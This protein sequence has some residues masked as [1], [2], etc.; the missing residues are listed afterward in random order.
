MHKTTTTKTKR[1]FAKVLVTAV[2]GIVGEGIIKSLKFANIS[3]HTPV[4]YEIF[5]VDISAQAAGLY[6][7]DHGIL[8]PPASSPNYIDFIIKIIKE[9]QIDALYVGS[10]VELVNI[11]KAKKRIETETDA[12][13]ITNPIEVIDTARDKWKTFEFLKSSHLPLAMSSLPQDKEKLIQ[14]YNFPLVVKP[15][16][17]YGSLHFY[18]VNNMEETEQAINMIQ[19]SGWRAMVQ[20]YL[21]ANYE[22]FTSGI[23]IDRTGRYVMSSITIRKTPKSGQ[24]YK[25]VIDSFDEIRKSA[26][27]VAKKLG[28]RSA[29]NIQ[30]KFNGNEAKVFEINPR[31]SATTPMRA[32][33]GINEPDIIFRNTILGEDIRITEYEKMLCLRYWNE[34]YVRY[35]AYEKMSNSKQI[36]E[37]DAFIIDYF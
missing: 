14:K 37:N 33:A 27:E 13:V 32:I 4:K 23:T 28:A 36:E 11:V 17:G 3:D 34:I 20:E 19:K 30:A 15:R 24:T 26:E 16:E 31:F 6:R 22:E 12:V 18:V 2:G 5:G 29:V 25:A 1:V 9:N 7:C 35:S 8:I 21:N 10:D